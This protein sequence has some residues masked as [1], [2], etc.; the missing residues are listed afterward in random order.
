VS[1]HWDDLFL[2]PEQIYEKLTGGV[3]SKSLGQ[4][5][6]STLKEQDM[7][8]DRAELIYSL[9]KLVKS[10]WQGDAADGAYGAAMPLAERAVENTVKLTG[11]QDLLARQV[12]S[13][14]RAFNSVVPVSDPPEMSVDEAFPFDVDH[15]K[16]VREHQDAAQNN[17][18]VYRE[19]D[20]A[21]HYNETNLPQEYTGDIRDSGTV[22]VDGADVIKV[23]GPGPG[24]G[25]GEPRDGG[26]GDGSYPGGGGPGPGGYRGGGPT[27][28]PTG[29]GGGPGSQTTPTDY[30]PAPSSG[31][32]SRYP[33]PTYPSPG[34]S[35]PVSGSPPGEFVGGV[36]VGGYGS[37]GFGPRGGGPGGVGG[38]GAG[39]G[40]GA[41]G[42]GG[43]AARGPLGA[44]AGAGARAAEEAAIARRAAQA[45]A[46]GA[47]PGGVGAVGGPAGSGRGKD[48][49]DQEHKRKVLIE[50]D[51]EGVFGSDE[52]T[53][54]EVIGDDEYED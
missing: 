42:P 40:P 35:S 17:I 33:L 26:P 19:Y 27:G 1:N 51:G 6:R 30:R 5:Q 4:E 43:G 23:G 37:G 28:G 32:P 2:T 18:A 41:G 13:F 54:P 20:G 15:D 49:E 46:S 52:L 8:A 22:S 12:D 34:Q 48:D 50:T 53:A 45:G 9:A 39:R 16:A 14:E 36:P 10:G 44:G 29:S 31:Y 47:R 25:S 7:E 21:S 11:A 24:P 3:G 38:P